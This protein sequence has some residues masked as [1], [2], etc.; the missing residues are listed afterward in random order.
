MSNPKVRISENR[1]GDVSYR[2][3]DLELWLRE[4]IS[5][6]IENKVTE[7]RTHIVGLLCS[8]VAKG[9]LTVNDVIEITQEYNVRDSTTPEVSE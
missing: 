9:V 8:L 4:L 3:E 6:C 2:T 7:M 1:N 5:G